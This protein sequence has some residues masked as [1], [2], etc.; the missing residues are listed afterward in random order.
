MKK[1]LTATASSIIS[2]IL[3]AFLLAAGIFCFAESVAIAPGGVT[4]ISIMLNRLFSLPVGLTGLVINIPLMIASYKYISRPLTLRTIRS[5]VVCAFILDGIVTPLFPQFSGDR[6]LGSIF[7]GVL[8]GSG[9]G[10]ILAG[11][12]ST[13]GTDTISLMIERKSSSIGIGQAM[14]IVDSIIIGASALVFGNIESALFGVVA[15]FCQTVVVDKLVYGSERGR[16]LIIIS[17]KSRAISRRILTETGRGATFFKG[18]GAF[19]G[20]SSEIIFCV[21]RAFE[22]K[23]VKSIIF[24]EDDRAFVITH[25]ASQITGEGF[26]SPDRNKK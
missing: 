8:M 10:V 2:D 19:S 5:L 22:Y 11:G 24:E 9:L 15:L 3:G 25:E 18:E 6:M 12:S 4:G 1:R 14:L 20:N 21:V 16:L 23:A 7:A 26:S 13:G 17:Q